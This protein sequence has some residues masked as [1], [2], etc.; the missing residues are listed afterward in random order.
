MARRA[1]AAFV[2]QAQR[3]AGAWARHYDPAVRLA[4]APSERTDHYALDFGKKAKG[5]VEL[6]AQAPRGSTGECEEKAIVWPLIGGKSPKTEPE[7]A[8]DPPDSSGCWYMAAYEFE[9]PASGEA[10]ALEVE[11]TPLDVL[12]LQTGTSA[13][14]RTRNSDLSGEG[15]LE[16]NPAFV[17]KTAAVAYDNP[18]VPVILAAKVHPTSE[19]T[20]AQT[21]ERVLAPLAT[22]G[23]G[24]SNQRLIKLWANYVFTLAGEGGE[25]IRSTNAILLADQINLLPEAG[26]NEEGVTLKELCAELEANCEAWYRYFQPSRREAALSMALVLFAD[27][28]GTKLPIIQVQELEIDVLPEWWPA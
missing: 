8:K 10:A 22:A 16:T 5:E 1:I 26:G 25:A 4:A 27:V 7:P 23:T 13:C 3:V 6:Y 9:P 14:W 19:G 21:L 24:V 12:S 11:W 28:E 17:Y 18:V 20:L 15:G 2:E